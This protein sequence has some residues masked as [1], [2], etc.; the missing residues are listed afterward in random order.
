MCS[1]ELQNVRGND[2]WLKGKSHKI[3]LVLKNEVLCFDTKELRK[4]TENKIQGKQITD[5]NKRGVYYEPY[6]RLS[7]IHI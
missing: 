3:A 2:G 1:N 5:E 4:W 7:L 6:Q